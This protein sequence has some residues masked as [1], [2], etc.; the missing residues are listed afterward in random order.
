[1][2]LT[3]TGGFDCY[4]YIE[5]FIYGKTRNLYKFV[6]SYSKDGDPFELKFPI[7]NLSINNNNELLHRLK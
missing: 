2:V 6:K 7:P 1:M 5:I 4:S 3:H